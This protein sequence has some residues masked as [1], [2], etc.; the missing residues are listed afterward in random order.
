MREA[1]PRQRSR[2]RASDLPLH[3]KLSHP[4]CLANVDQHALL[5][6]QISRSSILRLSQSDITTLV[7]GIQS[8]CAYLLNNFF[9]YSPHLTVCGVPQC[10]DECLMD[11][12]L[13]SQRLKLLQDVSSSSGLLPRPYWISDVTK[14]KRISVGGEATVYLGLHSGET[15][16]VREFHPVAPGTLSTPAIEHTKKVRPF[17]LSC[18][19]QSPVITL[20]YKI[21]LREIVG[22]WQLRHPNIVN[23]IGIHQ[24][25]GE[26]FPSMILQHVE[27]PSAA[28]YLELHPDPKSFLKLVRIRLVS[29]HR[30]LSASSQL[31]G[32]LEGIHYLHTR[33]PPIVHG[34]LHD[35]SIA[36]PPPNS[37]HSF[38]CN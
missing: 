14:G 36:P 31:F 2:I 10:I 4:R 22:H 30:P 37:L 29:P 24:F 15:V 7:T 16:V 12:D 26:S 33:S 17:D 35:V 13:T 20:L 21:I 8:V 6:G 9:I 38:M 1:D 25:D 3:L 34:D 28:E 5:G 18:F 19:L 27:H 23:L 11:A 32:L